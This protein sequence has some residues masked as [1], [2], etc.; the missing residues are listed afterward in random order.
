MRNSDMTRPITLYLIGFAGTGKYTIA[1]E[2]AKSG[3]KVVDNHLI[4]N[5]IFSLLDLDDETPIAENAWIS[6]R[7]IRHIILDFIAQDQKSNFIFTNALLEK[8]GDWKIYN[9]IK[10]TA[11]KRGSLFVPLKLILSPEEHEKRIASP[12][13]KA[14]FKMTNLAEVHI[15]KEMIK[16][17]HPHLTKIDV[18]NLSAGEASEKILSFVKSLESSFPADEDKHSVGEIVL[19]E[20]DTSEIREVLW[21][22]IKAFNQPYTGN[23]TT[24]PFALSIRDGKSKIIAGIYGFTFYD[25]A[26]V[27]YTWVEESYRQQGLGRKLFEKLDEFCRSKGCSVIQ[28]DTLDFQSPAFYE[29]MGYEYIGT[30]SEWINK[31]DCYFM[32][33][34]L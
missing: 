14:R 20:M 18:T 11:E 30:V 9:L 1:K 21:Q 16:I 2:I 27:E 31:H 8:E 17:D 5:P 10:E 4:N 32:R 25:H 29:K 7:K 19:D 23:I 3:Y 26:R 33:K 24:Q 34:I 28:L 6:V 15:K 13:R 22:G 12:D